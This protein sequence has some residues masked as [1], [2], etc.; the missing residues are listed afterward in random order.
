M[1]QMNSMDDCIAYME[2]QAKTVNEE[3]Q[4]YMSA[5]AGA[6]AIMQSAMSYSLLSGGKRIRPVLLLAAN[7]MC[8]GSVKRAL[9]FAC[10]LEMI[11][12]Y[13]LIH[14]D[15][16]AMDNDTLRRGKPTN[17]VVYGEAT[18]I[19]AGDALLNLAYE[20][21]ISEC[22]RQGPSALS[23]AQY[24]AEASG[25][26]G[27]IGGQC[28]DIAATG[29]FAGEEALQEMHLK[30]TGA[31]LK[32]AVLSGIALNNPSDEVI[33]AMRTY[34]YHL[35]MLFQITDDILDCV[36]S[37][38]ELGKTAGKDLAANKTTYVSFYGIDRAR[39]LDQDHA[40]RAVKALNGLSGVDFFKLTAKYIL[41]RKK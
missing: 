27:M 12:T 14:D 11:H 2:R 19:L 3:L 38:A 17:H 5:L 33:D 29:Q 36:G 9:P 40:D 20:V 16:P 22:L 37:A 1:M 32:A 15:L 31:V 4:R 10:A 34:G 26:R 41:E 25:C 6:P 35:G 21:M 30:K 18:A 39:E 8:C 13:S 28:L 23:T 24:I 7:E